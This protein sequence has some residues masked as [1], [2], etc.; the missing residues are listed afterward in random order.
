MKQSIRNYNICKKEKSYMKREV[1][2]VRKEGEG[3]V[4][5]LKN[6]WN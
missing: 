3:V 6:K 4:F 1:V 5:V 2:Y